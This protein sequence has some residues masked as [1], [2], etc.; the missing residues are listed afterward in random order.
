[1]QD[2]ASI[3]LVKQVKAVSL[4]TDSLGTRP[5]PVRQNLLQILEYIT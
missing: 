4:E 3:I 1:M 5:S 2:I